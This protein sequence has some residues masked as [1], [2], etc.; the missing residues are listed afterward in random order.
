[1]GN[2]AAA[3]SGPR[4]RVGGSGVLAV[5]MAALK[6]VVSRISRHVAGVGVEVGVGVGV[7]WI[8]M[9]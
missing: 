6:V 1:M 3:T 5:A 8:R 9:R 2:G 4:G 7:G